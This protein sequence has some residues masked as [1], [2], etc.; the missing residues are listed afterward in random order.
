MECT[1]CTKQLK[2][3][4]SLLHHQKTANYCLKIQGKFEENKQFICENCNSSFTLK[5]TLHKHINNCKNNT[6]FVKKLHN[7]IK[8]LENKVENTKLRLKESFSRE[9]S[10]QK[11]YDN[12]AKLLAKKPTTHNNSNVNLSIF[13]KSIEDI[14]RVVNEKYTKDYLRD[15]QTGVAQF[16]KRHLI[17]T[18]P[19]AP[20]EY[21]VTDRSRFHGKFIG[22]DN[23]SIPDTNMQGLTQ[24]IHPSIDKKACKIMKGENDVF[25][26][27]DLLNGFT[28]VRKM[29]HD[30]SQFCKVFTKI[31][32]VKNLPDGKKSQILEFI[33][34]DS[35]DEQDEQIVKMS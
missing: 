16:A 29:I 25:S 34:E 9:K 23:E 26:D 21:V 27:Q 28:E 14:D 15:G 32:D 6:V 7:R 31:H 22:A 5:S 13:S 17:N 11:R 19:G 33:I 18:D 20:L 3:K 35:S 12:L 10:L 8:E 2:T 1:F 30:N 4:H 24:K